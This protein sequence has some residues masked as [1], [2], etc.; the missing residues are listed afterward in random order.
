MLAVGRSDAGDGE[1]KGRG[2]QSPGSWLLAK[3]RELEISRMAEVPTLASAPLVA[4]RWVLPS[5]LLCFRPVTFFSSVFLMPSRR[6]GGV[7]LILS[8][9]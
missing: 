8:S 1:V 9:F 7:A 3:Q 4:V 5:R 6:C 2:P